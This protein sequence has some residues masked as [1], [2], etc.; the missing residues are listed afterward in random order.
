MKVVPLKDELHIALDP[1]SGTSV[2]YGKGVA[3]VKYT[4]LP[5]LRG[6]NFIIAKTEIEPAY[7]ETWNG[8]K[9]AIAAIERAESE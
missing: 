3:G 2:D 6:N 4:F 7:V 5:E 8:I 1:G 9:A